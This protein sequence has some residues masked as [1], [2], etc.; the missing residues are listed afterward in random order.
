MVPL[1][2]RIKLL[3][4][5]LD[6]RLSM[7]HH[8][9]NLCKACIFH[10]RAFCH[11]RP[12]I[13]DDTAKTIVSSLVGCRLDY[14]NSVLYG[15]SLTNIKW[16]QRVQ[17][18]LAR[19]VA[20]LPTCSPTTPTL[21]ELHWLPIRHRIDYKIAILTYK[22]LNCG[23]P[24]YLHSE[25]PSVSHAANY[26]HQLTLDALML[27]EQRRLL[28]VVLFVRLLQ[29]FGTLYLLT[30]DLHLASQLY[31]KTKD[32]LFWLCIWLTFI[33]AVQSASDS[34]VIG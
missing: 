28:L 14:A 32:I 3:G 10:I 12:A 5:I 13:N 33:T 11:I 17:N 30:L 18:W 4:V 24:T 1:T 31:E 26:V 19:V 21:K 23:E 29:P 34:A 6:K 20:R 7:D 8:V 9:A 25:Y 2:D 15:T 27:Y 22:V 16:L